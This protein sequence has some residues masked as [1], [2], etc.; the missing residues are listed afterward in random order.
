MA[1]V[2]QSP[3]GK[4]VGRYRDANGKPKVA[5]SYTR[6]T[7]AKRAA[8]RAEGIARDNP[9][10]SD[11]TFSEWVDKWWPTRTV[12]QRTLAEDKK[13]FDKR[14][15]PKWGDKPINKITTRQIQ[16]WVTELRDEGLSASTVIKHGHN[17]SA[18]L[19]AAVGAK[20]IPVNPCNGVTYPKIGTSPERFLSRDEA[21][22]VERLLDGTH[23]LVWHILLGTGFRWGEAAGLHW[24]HVDFDQRRIE[25]AVTWDHVVKQFKPPKNYQKR[26]VPMGD[27]L[28]GVLNTQLDLQGYGQSSD[29]KY[30]GVRQPRYGLV[31]PTRTGTPIASNTFGHILSAAGK[32]AVIGEGARRRQVGHIRPHDLRHTYGSWLVQAGIPLQQVQKLLGHSSLSVTERYAKI[33]N[34][35]WEEVRNTLR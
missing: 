11:M 8:E 17:L 22:A 2:Q 18:A 24:D 13:R 26:Y 32:A 12:G 29:A 3:S 4:W 21:D 5:G 28:A 16:E 14:L 7:D 23:L 30:D 10:Y 35:G 6:K 25:V 31:I 15:T 9:L 33:A 19:K 1:W 34:T 27:T 20:L